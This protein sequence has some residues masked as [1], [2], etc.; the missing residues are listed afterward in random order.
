[1]RI[2]LASLALAAIAS[3]ALAQ[4]AGGTIDVGGWKVSDTRENGAF[5]GCSAVN[6]FDDGSIVGL[7]ATKEV[8]FL[9]VSEPKSGL[10]LKQKYQIKYSFDNGK[11][12]TAEGEAHGPD[13]MLV[14]IPDSD[15]A[16]F[17]SAGKLNL[18]YGGNDYEEPLDGSKDAVTQMSTCMN[19]GLK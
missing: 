4:P 2:L 13:T 3:P 9:I 16:P 5:Q 18:S 8:T 10:T 17:M 19:A 14:P 6:K 12:T 11:Q 15:V 1:M 7:A